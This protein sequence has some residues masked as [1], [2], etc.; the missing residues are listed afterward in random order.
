MSEKI[1]I[2][3]LFLVSLTGCNRTMVAMDSTPTDARV[4]INQ[5]IERYT[6][7]EVNYS[8]NR[9]RIVYFSMRKDGYHPVKGFITKKGGVF[10]ERSGEIIPKNGVYHFE[11]IKSEAD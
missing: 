8:N 10:T 1:L 9:G 7:F 2:S 3:L 11:L 4:V 6:P 5:R